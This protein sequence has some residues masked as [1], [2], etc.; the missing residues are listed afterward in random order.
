MAGEE[1]M[2]KR[3]FKMG[4]GPAV[5]NDEFLASAKFSS[6]SADSRAAYFTQEHAAQR[7]FSR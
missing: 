3:K 1:K 7:V 2:G 5:W 6:I 4:A